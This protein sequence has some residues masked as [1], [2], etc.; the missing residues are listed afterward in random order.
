MTRRRRHR[1]R[2]CRRTFV[3][4][5]SGRQGQAG[6]AFPRPFARETGALHLDPA[7]SALKTQ[8]NAGPAAPRDQGDADVKRQSIDRTDPAGGAGLCRYRYRYRL[9]WMIVATGTG[10]QGCAHESVFLRGACS[11]RGLRPWR[12]RAALE[13]RVSGGGGDD[14]MRRWSGGVD[15]TVRVLAGAFE[16]EPPSDRWVISALLGARADQAEAPTKAGSV[17][18]SREPE[19]HVGLLSIAA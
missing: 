2:R 15:R 19:Q 18:H 9:R 14:A 3:V 1:W 6:A 16:S 7:R 4:P 10:R 8:A 12:P 5:S 17:G 13:R 11:R